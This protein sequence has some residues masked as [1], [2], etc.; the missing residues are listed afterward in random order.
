MERSESRCVNT[1][2]VDFASAR[3]SFNAEV[4]RKTSLL[5]SS[6]RLSTAVTTMFDKVMRKKAKSRWQLEKEL[7]ELLL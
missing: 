3:S 4:E 6:I 1:V 5:I 2:G 7:G